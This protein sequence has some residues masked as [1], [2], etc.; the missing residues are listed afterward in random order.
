M[1]LTDYLKPQIKGR[2]I[3]CNFLF[4]LLFTVSVF[5]PDYILKVILGLP[6]CFEWLFFGGVLLFGFLLSFAGNIACYTYLAIIFLMQTVQLNYVSYFGAPID[7]SNLMNIHREAADVF[8]FAYLRDTW[9][10]TPVLILLYGTCIYAFKKLPMVK[11]KWV[12]FILLYMAMHKPYRALSHTK[13][14]WYFQPSITRPSLRNSIS[15]FSYFF[16]Q[17]LPDGYQPLSVRY[18]PYSA[19][20]NKDSQAEN[21]L[22]I[23][24]ESLYAPHLQMYG[25]NRETFPRMGLRMNNNPEWHQALAMSGGI[26]TATSTLLFFN[27]IREPANAAEINAKTANIFRLA[28]QAGFKTHYFSN[29][30]SRLTMSFGAKNLDEIITNDTRLF[31]FSKYHDEGLALLLDEID[32]SEGK[33]FVVLHMRSPHS[34]FENRYHGREDEFEK[35]KP[36]ADSN[37]KFIRYQNTYDNALLYTD[38]AIDEMVEKFEKLNEGKNYSIYITAD[39]GELVNF[40]GMYGHNNLVLEQAKVPFFVKRKD[41]IEL[42][43]VMSHYQIIKFMADDFG[44]S[45]NNPNENDN[46]Y[47]L[48]GNNVDFPYN[49][50]EYRIEDDGQITQIDENNTANLK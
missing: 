14:I 42:P 38:L 28:K 9:F 18:I 33:N 12:W 35:F 48:H 11:I 49:F 34:P 19:V 20:K 39:H 43:K 50:I 45:I 17:Y 31:F 30:E 25:Y 7:A 4:M 23:F 8:D 3:T 44:F 24:G 27:G 1:N 22:L 41:N 47:Y 32:F 5:L 10:N 21:V 2:K 29:Q 15:T 46:R 40:E 37:D 16:F 13:N 26:A 6:I 36:A